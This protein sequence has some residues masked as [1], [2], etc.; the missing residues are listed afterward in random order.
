MLTKEQIEEI[1]LCMIEQNARCY[2]CSIDLTKGEC[3]MQLLKTAIKLM[4]E[5]EAL[6]AKNG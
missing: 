1:E 6:K 5:N 2:E 3:E 4:I